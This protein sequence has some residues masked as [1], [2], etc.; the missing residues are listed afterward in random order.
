MAPRGWD[1]VSC[2]FLLVILIAVSAAFFECTSTAVAD[3]RASEPPLPA[4]EWTPYAQLTLARALTGEGGSLDDAR[5]MA[6]ILARRW[7]AIRLRRTWSFAELVTRYCAPLRRDVR[8]T[9]RRAR[10][11]A[12]EWTAL[13]APLRELVVRWGRGLEPDPCHGRAH[14]FDSPASAARRRVRMRRVRCTGVHY[15]AYFGR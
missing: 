13:Q 6:W 8:L 14:H 1:A 3:E 2:L 12:L 5:A 15:Q 10:I 7:H 4:S 11:R 9:P